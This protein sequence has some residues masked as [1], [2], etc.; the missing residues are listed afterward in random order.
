MKIF[1]MQ[2]GTPEWHGV[3]AGVPTASQFNRIMT[4]AKREYSKGVDKYM[5]ELLEDKNLATKG[6][7]EAIGRYCSSAMMHGIE[8]EGDA[9]DMYEFIEGTRVD[10]VGFIMDDDGR[11]GYS[12]DGMVGKS[13][14]V[15]IKCP[16]RKAHEKYI[17]DGVLPRAYS[18]Q[19]HGALIVTG[20]EWIDFMS[21]HEGLEPF[22]IRVEWS[23]QTDELK[24]NL[25]RF[26]DEWSIERNNS[27]LFE[28]E[29][30]YGAVR[31]S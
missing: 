27:Q 4:P 10:Q 18:G 26:W 13:G 20:R 28:K 14:L 22:V 17:K 16:L 1:S 9:R 15:E 30:N 12:P 8:T 3:R 24:Q 5:A 7:P 23:E 25:E 31:R 2:Q 29:P 6:T 21:Y 19:C 11:F